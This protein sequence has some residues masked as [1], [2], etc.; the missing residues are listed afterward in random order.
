MK[1]YDKVMVPR[2][3]FGSNTHE[4]AGSI[5]KSMGV[6]NCLIVTGPNVFK[7]GYV[8]M[9][10]K[11]MDAEGIKYEIYKDSKPD[12][13]DTAVLYVADIIKKGGYDGVIGMGGGSPMDLAKAA[14]LAA[15]IFDDPAS[16]TD[17]HEY[18]RGNGSLHRDDWIRKYPLMTL[19]TTSGTGA[20][21]TA[22][23]AIADSKT[24]LKFSF[25]NQ[26]I[27]P[28][29]A[30]IDPVFTLG[31]P[32]LPTANCA[33]DA[34]AHCVEDIV[35]PGKNEYTNLIQYDCIERIW[36]WLPI[37]MEDPNDLEAR[38]Q[39]SWSAH[40]ALA[41]G[42]APNGHAVGHA[43]TSFYHMVHGPSC[44]IVLP[45]VIR[46]HA[47]ASQAEIAELAKRID[48]PLTGAAKLDAERVAM[49]IYRF[50]KKA[51][52]PSLQEY[53]EQNGYTDTKEEFVKK[54]VPFVLDDW[55]SRN[56]LPPIHLKDEDCA[57]VCAQ[58]YDDR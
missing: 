25:G 44:A 55:K 2:I 53:M 43:I 33:L 21:A 34:L 7:R 4:K 47:E 29:V 41:N 45:T 12:P 26:A 17:L 15:S 50:Y 57:A 38:E 22:S 19:T 52:I 5:L 51:G 10:T 46:H 58:V 27:A 23:A 35:S 3:I 6:T 8:D 18:R 32:P 42:G 54:M 9:V 48:V 20:E 30:I 1:A 37:A 16:I 56:W 40:N 14:T 49:A 24:H 39:L 11:T 36:K 28:D 13:E 31:M